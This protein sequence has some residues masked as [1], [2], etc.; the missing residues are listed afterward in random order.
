MRYKTLFGKTIKN[1]SS[2]I[3]TV[4]HKLLI[5]SGFIRESTA[6]RYFNLPLGMRVHN[7]VVDIIRGEMNKSGAQEMVTPVLH[8]IN[9][10]EKTNRMAS[11]GFELT[12]VSDRRG[13]R[14]V[15]GGTAEEMFV[16][17]VKQFNLSYKDLPFNLYQFSSKFRDEL[18]VRGGLLRAREFTMKDAYSFDRNEKEF[19]KTYEK[20]K[21]TY[22]KIFKLLG[23]ETVVVEADNGYI[24][25]EYCHEFQVLSDT[26]EDM[27][28]YVKSIDKYFNREIAPSKAQ[29]TEYQDEKLEDKKDV[30]G[31][32]IIGVEDLARYLN[33][34]VEKTTKTLLFE[35][36]NNRLIA[37]AVR[38]G[39]D[40]DETKL[41]RVAKTS[42]LKLASEDMI[43]K[44]TSAEVGYLGPL[45]LPKKVEIFYD[46]ST[47]S[48]INFECGAN[49]TN[50]HT[51]NVNWGRDISK[52]EEF[53]D[54]K[55]TKEGDLYPETGEKYEVYRGI[56][57]GNIFQ[58]GYHYSKLMN[59]VFTDEDGKEKLYYMGCYGIGI[60]RT[61]ATIVEKYHDDKGIIW[62]ENIAPFKVEVV[63]L[64]T[65]DEAVVN[66]A[67]KLYKKLLDSNV[68]VLFDDRSDVSA[69]E[70]LND[71]DLLGISHR[72]VISKK[73]V[74][75]DKIEYK[76]RDQNRAVLISESDFMSKLL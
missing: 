50:Y 1:V 54:I 35:G 64:N 17:V 48:R 47:D 14:F 43:K 15:L 76:K 39:Y 9:L 20:M 65:E 71:A 16:D 34:P 4:S 29:P 24:G 3:K 66:S 31:K 33:I 63:L 28:F 37:A 40:I 8:P 72:I 67:N 23:L 73:T 7:K 49:K 6:G 55:V 5:K 13:T 61:I 18:R 45:N 25:G 36:N 21:E 60:G 10:W 70:K 12:T 74:I 51:I 44:L 56:E 22:T 52:P 27:L 62:P 30:L 57:V 69:G 58:L 11:V 42:F 26:G 68:E 2:E 19:K 41:R 32:G 38:G 46:E 75:S 59:A 53:Y